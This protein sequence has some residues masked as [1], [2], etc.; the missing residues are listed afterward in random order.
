MKGFKD[1]RKATFHN[2]SAT[3]GESN[4][5]NTKEEEH[6]NLMGAMATNNLV[7]QSFG[8]LTYQIEK[9]NRIG[10]GN[11]ARIAQPKKK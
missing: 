7:E 11:V 2:F 8:L 3:N 10:F 4:W 9:F 6:H 1:D 5:E